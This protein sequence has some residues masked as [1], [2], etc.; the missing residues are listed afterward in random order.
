MAESEFFSTRF[1]HRS[2]AGDPSCKIPTLTILAAEIDPPLRRPQTQM[3]AP[4]FPGAQI[5]RIVDD[6]IDGSCC[7]AIVVPQR[8]AESLAALDLSG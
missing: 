7:R 3:Q 2:K 1:Y 6:E 8:A 4:T 5:R